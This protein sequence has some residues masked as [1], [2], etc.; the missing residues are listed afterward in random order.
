MPPPFTDNPLC[1]CI[2]TEP[3]AL[4]RFCKAHN[5][6]RG[7]KA[8][9]EKVTRYLVLQPVY[10]HA[11]AQAMHALF[12][13]KIVHDDEKDICTML[14]EAVLFEDTSA[15]TTPF[16]Y[17]VDNAPLSPDEKRLYTA[18]RSHTRHGLLAV[19]KVIPGEEVHVAALT[20]EKRYRVYEQRAT[21]TLKKG[22]VVMARIVPFLN[23]WMFTTETILSFSGSAGERLQASYGLVIPQFVFVRKYHEDHKRRMAG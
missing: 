5:T 3:C 6:Q 17:F 13:D 14:F 21:T 2:E 22:A 19:E 18:W 10:Q 1:S 20:G 4:C 12:P 8:L 16:S 11:L 15:G 9:C 7:R 23:A